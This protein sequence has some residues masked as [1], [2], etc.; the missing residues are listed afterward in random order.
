MWNKGELLVV[1]DF[2]RYGNIRDYLIA[3]RNSFNVDESDDKNE[4]RSYVNS[5]EPLKDQEQYRQ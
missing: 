3:N 2:C 1:E 5:V 4:L